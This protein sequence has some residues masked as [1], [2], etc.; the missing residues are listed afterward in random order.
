MKYKKEFKQD[1][2]ETIGETDSHYDLSNYV[3]WLDKK[4]NEL[5]KENEELKQQLKWYENY[6]AWHEGDIHAVNPKDYK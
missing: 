2:P 4:Y 5:Q 3:D 1:H 6:Q